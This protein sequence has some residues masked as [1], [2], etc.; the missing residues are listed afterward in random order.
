MEFITYP[1]D[2]EKSITPKT[3]EM[4]R[5]LIRSLNRD[6]QKY[7]ALNKLM[8]E[9]FK[10]DD[11]EENNEK[12]F[13]LENSN[14]LRV[15]NHFE[16]NFHLGNKKALFYNM[17]AYSESIKKDVFDCLPLTFHIQNGTSDKEYY[18]FLNIYNK[19]KMEMEGKTIKD[20]KNA[21][22]KNLWIIKPGEL[23]NRGNG[24]TI[25]EDLSEINHILNSKDVHKNGKTKTYILQQYIEKPLLYNKRKLD[26]RC[27][28]LLT[29]VNNIFKGTK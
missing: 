8:H 24:I 5:H 22:T 2:L 19:I 27:Y 17:R 1:K 23:T 15:H 7:P 3:E 28:I 13:V 6:F 4:E 11:K 9:N 12:F 10:F 16:N 18:T 21:K 25:S 20:E 14:Y 26:I 29:N